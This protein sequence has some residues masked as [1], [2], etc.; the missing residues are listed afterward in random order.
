MSSTI[1][2]AGMPPKQIN[3]LNYTGE[4]LSTVPVVNVPRAP[5]V[6]DGQFPLFTLWRNANPSAVLPDAEGD[7]WYYARVNATVYPA[8]H[9]WN[10]IATGT[11][12]GGS[13]IG[14]TDTA[15]TSVLPNG[16]G[17]IQLEGT[18]GITIT[19]D[20]LNNK[21]TFALGGGGLAIDSIAVPSGTT[22]VVPT[23]AGLVT[24][25]VGSG[26]TLTGGLNNMTFDLAGG[27]IATQ[28][29]DI[30]AA[31]APG[32][33]PVVPTAGGVV[34]V[35][36]AAVAA[37][38][39]PVETRSRAAN[40]Y[41]VEVQYGSAVAATDATKSGLAHFNSAMFT[42]DA[43]GFVSL[44][45]GGI[46]IDQV[47]V[48][49]F[50]AP[51]TNPVLATAGGQITVTG[52]Q[53]AAG[54]V[55]TNVIR[56]DSL[57]ANTYT[58][59]IQRSTTAAT[60]TVASNGVSHY[61]SADF[62]VD[63]SAFV[64]LNPGAIPQLFSNLSIA[65]NAGTGVF[66]VQGYDGTALS[67]SNPG[68][69][70]TQDSATPGRLR[71]YT[72]TANQSFIDDNG[73]SQIIGNL[74][75]A[76]TGVAITDDIPFFLYLA[77]NDA[78]DTGIF[79]ISRVPHMQVA[80]AV[81]FIGTPASAVADTQASLFLFSSVTVADYDAN[82]V[83]CV[84]CFRMRMSALDDW[85]VQTLTTQEGIGKFYDGEVWTFPRGQFGAAAGKWFADNGGTAPNQN[86]PAGY[87]Y[88]IQKDGSCRIYI[89][90]PGITTAGVG[91]VNLKLTLPFQAANGGALGSG[92]IN[93]VGG[94][95]II[96]AQ[97]EVTQFST[98]IIYVEAAAAGVTLNNSFNLGSVMSFEGC[99]TIAR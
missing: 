45:G 79:G 23:A 98:P 2:Q 60:S 75:G 77:T 7:L 55:G 88:S 72:I 39:V 13:M 89:A 71:K 83:T 86:A 91:A 24:F 31:T 22:P 11:T 54:T 51:G 28:S 68:I 69:V 64:A 84:G 18:A 26:L 80:P 99:F 33:D 58:V 36:G 4:S 85:T 81:G 30:Q 3:S 61:K 76:T 29:F 27:G 62:T 43:N 97:A 93:T 20:P 96:S 57:A 21:L 50:T 40:A 42:V 95:A 32:T 34:T 8:Q 70:W 9:V 19:S 10:K 49:S 56:T 35:N 17:F 59:E 46:A 92:Y 74:F 6:N 15:L 16:A 94:Y 73:A 14:L 78:Q 53:V 52:A 48:D 44:A 47:A 25:N 37:H 41:N 87:A 63:S 82:P 66:S 38:S 65:Y 67:S 1:Y 12:P 90:I 5:T